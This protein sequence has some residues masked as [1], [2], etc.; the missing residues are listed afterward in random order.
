MK[1]MKKSIIAALALAASLTSCNFSDFGDINISPNAPGAPYTSMLFT[2][3]CFSARNF[4]SASSYDYWQPSFVGY[5]A[6]SKNNQF[7]SLATTYEFDTR[8]YYYG[9]LKML[10]KIIEM[11]KDP[12]LKDDLVYVKPFCSSNE[13]QIA[14]ALTLRAFYMM[15]L[16]DLVGALPWSEAWKGESDDIWFPK[17]DSQ[18]E[19]Y[20]ALFN[21]LEEAYGMFQEG[22]NLSSADI[23]I[24][25]NI[26]RWKKFNASIRMDMALRISDVD[27]GTAKSRFA[28]AYNQGGIT[29][30]AD[31]VLY[32]YDI[33]ATNSPL[34]PVGCMTYDARNLSWGPNKIIVEAL[35]EYKDP[36]MFTRFTI[37]D[38]AYLGKR[39]GD[40][41]DFEAYFGITHGHSG[42]GDVTADAALACSFTQK[43][44]T[45]AAD[46]G[47]FTAARSLFNMA[48]AVQR[49]L[50]SGDAA[51]LY[52]KAVRSS[53][54]F[55]GA[56][57]VDE[58]I[59]AHPL[60]SD[61]E[62]AIREISM[63]RWIAGFMTDCV[64]VYSDWRRTN[65]PALPLTDFQ[66]LQHPG[67][68]TMPSRFIYSD[69]DKERNPDQYEAAVA[70]Y[71]GGN[72]DR[73]ARVWWD[74]TPNE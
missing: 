20:T 6:E 43:Y 7:G 32:K 63:Q 26:A 69:T 55:E 67:H 25:G 17:F 61:N 53:F 51:A 28:T 15:H 41:T 2:N 60:P 73:W 48:E 9:S 22:A 36:R 8:G 34:Y 65:V 47:L 39:D 58:Y 16:T 54:A 37:G 50:I 46:Y 40:P 59:A 42:N 38:D 70:Q 71:L 4:I 74:V 24:G 11:N 29:E 35:K 62:G 64:E 21:D 66:Q 18:Q 33:R 5:M 57:D 10:N 12:E 3:A 56:D 49:G 72:D 44:C 27:A 31:Q 52:E 45:Q 30:D 13:N 23:L 68:T 1:I 14:A 19:I